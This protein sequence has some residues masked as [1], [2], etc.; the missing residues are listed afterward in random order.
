M[1]GTIAA[2]SVVALVAAGGT[3]TA[4]SLITSSDIKNGTIQSEDIKNGTIKDVDIQDGEVENHNIKK[5]SITMSRL[6]QTT[7]DLIREKGGGP[8]GPAGPAGAA[9]PQGAQGPRG[10]AGDPAPTPEYGV[11]SVF[12]V[13]ATASVALCDLLRPARLTGRND[14]GRRLPLLLH[15][16]PGALQGLLRG[17]GHLD[18]VG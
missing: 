4:A 7:Q 12:V 14:H 10:P 13:E 2:C 1:K 18:P 9:G 8:A 16:R 6:A 3:A 15:A 11:V 17:C 5:A